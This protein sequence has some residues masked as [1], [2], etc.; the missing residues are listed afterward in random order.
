MLV[1]TAIVIVVITTVAATI[2]IGP[3]PWSKKYGTKYGAN[4]TFAHHSVTPPQRGSGGTSQPLPMLARVSWEIS[5]SLYP[6]SP[7]PKGWRGQNIAHQ[8]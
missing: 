4:F 2:N 8:K 7:L 1:G 5:V 6:P 3:T